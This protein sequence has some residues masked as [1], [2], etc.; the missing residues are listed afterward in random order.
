MLHQLALAS[1]L[2]LIGSN[3]FPLCEKA[4]PGHCD[5]EQ[6]LGRYL[7]SSNPLTPKGGMIRI[8]PDTQGGEW[9]Y[10]HFVWESNSP[11]FVRTSGG[12][13]VLAHALLTVQ[14]S[15]GALNWLIA[16]TA[17]PEGPEPQ[18]YKHE[19]HRS[20]N[21]ITRRQLNSLPYRVQPIS[22][23]LP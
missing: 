19:P 6:F 4:P 16:R 12:A 7:K 3:A 20:A 5:S 22:G 2:L 15:A 11:L 13:H 14:V 23:P 18:T 1:A 9:D 17:R 8:R 21:A 10:A